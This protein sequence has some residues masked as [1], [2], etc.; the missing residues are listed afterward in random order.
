[1]DLV[2]GEIDSPSFEN[3]G[4]AMLFDRAKMLA[5]EV[6]F[7]LEDSTTGGASDGN[8]TAHKVPTLDGLGVLG[9]GTHTLQEHLLVSSL[10]PRMTLLRRLFETLT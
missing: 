8:F 3:A 10:V 2:T 7:D 1:L 6:G 5:K 4:I 9:R